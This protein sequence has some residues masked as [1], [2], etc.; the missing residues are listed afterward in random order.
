MRGLGCHGHDVVHDIAVLL[1][2]RLDLGLDLLRLVDRHS[3]EH[4]EYRWGKLITDFLVD[5][6]VF[7]CSSALPRRQT[8]RESTQP[9]VDLGVAL[10][11]H[12]IATPNICAVISNEY[13]VG[14]RRQA[15][16]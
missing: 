15:I 2:E 9:I 11:L 16:E 13:A 4:G 8:I 3:C 12:D 5:A 14:G 10:G 1:L 6:H 7:S